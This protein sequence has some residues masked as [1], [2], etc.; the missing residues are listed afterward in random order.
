MNSVSELRLWHQMWVFVQEEAPHSP[1][2]T[3]PKLKPVVKVSIAEDEN[4]CSG[5][6]AEWREPIHAI[7]RK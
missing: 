4:K 1:L 5:S 3:K 2:A 6:G 7:V